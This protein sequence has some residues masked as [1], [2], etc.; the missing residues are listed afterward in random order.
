MEIDGS[1]FLGI[2]WNLV[3]VNFWEFDERDFFWN[4]MEFGGS[5]FL[6]I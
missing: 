4:L 6:R 5:E 2:S 3:E 1:E